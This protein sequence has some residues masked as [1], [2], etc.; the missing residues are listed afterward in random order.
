[1][2]VQDFGAEHSADVDDAY[3]AIGRYMVAFSQL[4]AEMR[5]LIATRLGGADF[6]LVQIV[7]GEAQPGNIAHAFFGLAREVGNL[8]DAENDV[9][10]SLENAVRLA[11]EERT[12]FAHGDWQVGNV[13]VDPTSRKLKTLPPRRVRIL[14]HQK[15]GPY[16]IDHLTPKQIDEKTDDLLA[17]LTSV[18]EFGRLALGLPVTVEQADGSGEN[19]WLRVSDVF[20]VEG[21]QK[22]GKRL[23]RSGPRAD[24]VFPVI[25]VG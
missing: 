7:L 17:L 9:A 6:V 21:N 19:E 23:A 12:H 10:A 8:T 18:Y 25:Y 24:D 5:D 22:T 16:K 13:H 20:V 11:N 4:I 14:P 2:T 15:K 1:M 3:R